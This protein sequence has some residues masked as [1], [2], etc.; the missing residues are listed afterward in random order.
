MKSR[1][2]D[3]I[4]RQGTA[5]PGQRY[6]YNLQSFSFCFPEIIVSF[7]FANLGGCSTLVWNSKITPEV[8]F[9]FFL[10]FKLCLLHKTLSAAVTGISDKLGHCAENNENEFSF[11]PSSLPLSL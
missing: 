6:V 11:Q 4:E 3:E 5:F 1:G 7:L 10:K 2:T 9:F 8:A